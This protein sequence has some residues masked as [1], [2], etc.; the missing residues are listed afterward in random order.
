MKLVLSVFAL[1]LGLF[2]VRPQ[3]TA[4]DTPEAKTQE[5]NPNMVAG[6]KAVEA[7]DFKAAVGHFT[8]A[9]EAEPK[10]ADA[11]SLL[12]YSYRKQ[13]TLDKSME[14]YQRALKLDSNHRGAHEYLGELYLDMNQ[15]ENA[16]KQLA[17]LKKA[18]PWFGK[19]EQYDD[20][21]KAVDEYKVKKK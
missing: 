14:Y 8:K 16:E 17:A 7:K 5:E 9:V 6:R 19:C 18:C 13:G 11:Y 21:K 15:I 2:F 3:V 4:M 12:G 1:A 20:L 10:N